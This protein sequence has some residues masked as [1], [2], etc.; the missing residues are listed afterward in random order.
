MTG[1]GVA[2]AMLV[3]LGPVAGGL[4]VAAHGRGR[5]K[6]HDSPD[7]F[8]NWRRTTAE[9]VSVWGPRNRGFVLVRYRVGASLIE[10]DAPCSTE[11]A[12]LRAGQPVAI[13]YHPMHPARFVLDEER[14][15]RR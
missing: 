13:R 7:E 15:S 12:A 10:N 14:I 5:Q 3:V 2:L 6:S 1:P 9:V 4:Y 8:H 11:G